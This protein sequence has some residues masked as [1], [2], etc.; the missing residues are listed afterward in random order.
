LTYA[1]LGAALIGMAGG[2]V[3]IAA[4]QIFTGSDPGANSTDPRPLSNAAA[5]AFDTVAASLS[6]LSV[7]TFESA[8]VGTFS[9]LQVAPG[10]VLSGEDGVQI[11]DTPFNQPESI[12]GY[13]TTPGGS[14]FASNDLLGTS[15]ITFSFSQP[16]SAFGAYISGVQNSG[17]TVIFSDGSTETVPIPAGGFSGGIVFVGLIDPDSLFTRVTINVAFALGASDIVG[18]DDVRFPAA[19]VPEPSSMT[20]LGIGLFG[21]LMTWL[22]VPYMGAYTATS[23]S[24]ARRDP[25]FNPYAGTGFG[26]WS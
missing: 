20:L 19:V 18:V 10:V 13:N 21:L 9:S 8:P 6:P 4:P 17:E 24:G 3:A 1:C 15:L 25:E 23:G 11:R 26:S 14:H 7:I 5:A 16:I 2:P 12:Y 22:A